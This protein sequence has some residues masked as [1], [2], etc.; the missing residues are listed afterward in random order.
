MIV[1][2]NPDMTSKHP[3]DGVWFDQSSRDGSRCS[4][5]KDGKSNGRV[6]RTE[7]EMAT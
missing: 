4:Y 2:W 1:I 6:R 5:E 3:L 7:R